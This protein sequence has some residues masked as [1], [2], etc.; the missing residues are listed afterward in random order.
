MNWIRSLW[1]P[2]VLTL[3]LMISCFLESSQADMENCWS[4]WTLSK[5]SQSLLTPTGQKL[6]EFSIPLTTHPVTSTGQNLSLWVHS[7]CHPSLGGTPAYYSGY[8]KS[9]TF[10]GHCPITEWMPNQLELNANL[11]SQIQSSL[12]LCMFIHSYMVISFFYC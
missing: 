8:K 5:D 11:I 3:K 2:T 7:V 1:V 9:K 6:W 12:F 4:D 10:F